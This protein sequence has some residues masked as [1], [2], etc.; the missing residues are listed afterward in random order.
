MIAGIFSINTRNRHKAK[1]SLSK[2]QQEGNKSIKSGK[3]IPTSG[4]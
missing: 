1:E 2:G 3:K 4:L